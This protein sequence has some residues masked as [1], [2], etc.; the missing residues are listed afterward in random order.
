[1]SRDKKWRYW[2]NCIQ[3]TYE[4]ITALKDSEEMVSWRTFKQHVPE[5]FKFFKDQKAFWSDTTSRNIEN[6]PFI[7]FYKGTFMGR[8]TY[9]ARWSGIEW[10]W[11]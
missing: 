11:I 5:A 3:S 8:P 6:S 9:F 2:G 10:I 1:M 7:A 4:D